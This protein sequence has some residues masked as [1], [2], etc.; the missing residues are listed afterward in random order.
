MNGISKE[1][2]LDAEDAKVRDGMLYD[3]LEGIHDQVSFK[4]TVFVG[5]LGGIGAVV[6]MQSS[7]LLEALLK[8][9]L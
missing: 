4:R 6:V 3:M 2:F 8:L 9:L 5:L 7:V 1:S